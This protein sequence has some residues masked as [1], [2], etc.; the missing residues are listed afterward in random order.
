[1]TGIDSR[2]PTMLEIAERQRDPQSTQKIFLT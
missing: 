1:M 2:M